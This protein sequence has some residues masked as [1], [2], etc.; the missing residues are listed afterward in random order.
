M[1]SD[2]FTGADNT[3]LATHDSNWINYNSTFVVSSLKLSS[4]T[5][6]TTGVWAT[7]GARYFSSTRDEI[8]IV[9]KAGSTA[10]MGIGIRLA[11]DSGLDGYT[12]RIVVSSGNLSSFGVYRNNVWQ[13]TFTFGS[14]FAASS[15]HTL[16]LW[17]TGTSPLTLHFSIDGIEAT[18]TYTDNNPIAAG[19]PGFRLGGDGTS[20]VLALD[21]W[22]DG[23]SAPATVLFRRN[24]TRRAGSR[25]VAS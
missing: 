4:N 1:A 23:A 14:T 16:R 19:N 15:D 20:P 8:Q 17:A 9:R 6:V 13:H 10:E 5:C 11:G 21:D 22:S 2:S 24:R 18:S 12:V 7:A 3:A 25:G